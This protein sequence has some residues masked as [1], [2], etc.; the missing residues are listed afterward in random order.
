[1]SANRDSGIYRL[2]FPDGSAYI[3]ASKNITARVQTQ[4][5]WLRKNKGQ[6]KVLQEKY[7]EFGE[8]ES[9]VVLY[10]SPENLRLYEMLVFNITDKP[11]CR[12]VS[13]GIAGKTLSAEAKKNM[14]EAAKRKDQTGQS[15]RQLETWADPEI[16]ARRIAGMIKHH[17][18]RKNEQR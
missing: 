6:T 9:E 8:P 2:K 15:A 5:S 18:R 11:L 14:S 7:D 16:R 1:M 13:G 12:P 4:L 17:Q 10:C 3:G